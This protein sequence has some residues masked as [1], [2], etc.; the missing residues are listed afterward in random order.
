MIIP[1]EPIY[2]FCV[3]Q[4]PK[5]R[6]GLLEWNNL[7]MHTNSNRKFPKKELIFFCQ[8]LWFLI[9]I[10][11]QPDIVD[12]WYFK[13]KI[14]LGQVVLVLNIKGCK[15]IKIWKFEFVAKTQFLGE[16]LKNT[17]F[18]ATVKNKHYL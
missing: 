7:K 4:W 1:I 10:F 14:L 11:L 6:F 15:D 12:H 8:K 2:I 17:T 5:E 13:L 9:P 18:R 3:A 16:W